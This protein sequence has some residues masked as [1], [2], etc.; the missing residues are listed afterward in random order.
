MDRARL[1]FGQADWGGPE[2]IWQMASRPSRSALP[3]RSK[4]EC[5]PRSD[6]SLDGPSSGDKFWLIKLGA[7][8]MPMH[9]HTWRFGPL[10]TGGAGHPRFSQE[11]PNA[12]RPARMTDAGEQGKR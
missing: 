6:P 1:A 3:P 11:L 4:Q 8:H 2:S 7:G 10:P 5:R 9:M 12:H